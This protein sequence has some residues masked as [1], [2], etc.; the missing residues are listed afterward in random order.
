MVGIFMNTDLFL[1]VRD[2]DMVDCL[3][4]TR[5]LVEKDT[6]TR[7]LLFPLLGNGLFFVP[8]DEVWKNKRKAITSGLYKQRLLQFYKDAKRLIVD[9]MEDLQ[10]NYVDTKIPVDLLPLSLSIVSRCIFYFLFGEDIAK[11]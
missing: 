3:F 7:D 8:T 2:P 5:D 1:F 10:K 4:T 6:Y 9:E 11:N